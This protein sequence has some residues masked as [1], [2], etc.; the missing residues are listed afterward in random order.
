M[1]RFEA[2]GRDV[3]CVMRRLPETGTAD[4]VHNEMRSKTELPGPE[5]GELSSARQAL[6]G[7]PVAPG[8]RNT[9]TLLQ[10]ARRR[11][12]EPREPLPP[13]LLRFNPDT[14]FQ[15]DEKLFG[16]NLRSSRRGVVGGPSAMTSE[17]LRPLLDEQ[18]GTHLLFRLGENLAKAQVS[19]VAAHL[20]RAGRMTAWAKEDGGVR[21]IV[22]GDVV[23]RLVARTTAQQSGP[24]VKV[25]TAPHQYAL[26]TRTECECIAHVLQALCELNPRATVTS[27]DGISAH[28]TISRKSML[29]GLTRVKGR[30]P[31]SLLS[32][33]FTENLRSTFGKMTV[34]RFTPSCKG[35]RRTGRRHDA[36][37]LLSGAAR[38]FGERVQD[39]ACR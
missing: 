1:A 2:F 23:R 24:A 5:V 20:L 38:G 32:E 14:E 12:P 4:A 16:R 13:G 6:E 34:V 30:M 10:D 27:V 31:Q 17:R 7:A 22:T 3:F 15:L 21:G 39:F 8:N 9:L 29:E 37:A 26:S 35:G 19:P 25:A 33:C 11:P 36:A 18:R 28:E